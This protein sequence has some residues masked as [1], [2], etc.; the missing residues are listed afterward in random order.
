M[1]A[2][3]PTAEQQITREDVRREMAR[4]GIKPHGRKQESGRVLIW[5]GAGLMLASLAVLLLPL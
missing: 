2:I 4:Q 3:T 1:S 5:L